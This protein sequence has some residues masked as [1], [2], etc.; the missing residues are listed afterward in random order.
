MKYYSIDFVNDSFG[1]GIYARS[2]EEARKIAENPAN[3]K[4]GSHELSSQF[5][6]GLFNQL[7]NN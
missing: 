2:E 1:I 6:N 3:W 7:R 4:D 5:V